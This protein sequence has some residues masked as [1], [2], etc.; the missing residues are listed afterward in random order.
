[1]DLSIIIVNYNVKHFL[2]QCLY[3]VEKAIKHLSA[4]VFVVDNNSVDG[5]V[6]MLKE[7]FLH[8]H[9]ILNNENYGF[10][11]ANNQA[12]EKATGKYILLLNP[13][14][15]VEEDTFE[16]SI[17]FM[18]ANTDAGGLG[19]KMIDGKGRF[20]PESKRSLP[21]PA[22]AF[23]KIFGF[24]KLF[25]KSKRF[26]KYHLSYLD[27][28]KTHQVE[29]LSGAFMM[30][31]KTV[32][33]KIGYLDETFFMY[34]EDIDLSYRITLAGYKNYY[35]ANTKIIHYKGESTKKG[36]INYV[37]VFYKAMIIFAKKHFKGKQVK[38]LSFLIH[39]GIFI[40]AFLSIIVR[41]AK[42]VALP[43]FDFGVIFGGLYAIKSYW[44]Y[45][46]KYIEGGHYPP[47]F[48][49]FMIPAYALVW[50]LGIYLSGGYDKPPKLLK[51]FR[52]IIYGTIFILVAYALLDEAYRYS[53]AII[54]LGAAFTFI[55][56]LLTRIV[57]HFVNTGT[58]NLE[59]ITSNRFVIIGD[60]EE[61]VRVEKLLHLTGIQTV[62]TGFVSSNDKKSCPQQIGT[63]S[64]I[65]DI[66]TIYN[67]QEIIFCAKNLNSNQIIAKMVQLKNY[68]VDFKIAP[69]QSIALIGSNSINTAGDMYVLDINT[70]IE[71][72]NKRNKRIFDVIFSVVVF[73]ASPL[74]LFIKPKQFG[75]LFYNA[76][77]VFL[78][79]KSWVGY[80]NNKNNL[81]NLPNIK[82]GVFSPVDAQ[83]IHITDISTINNLN[84]LYAKDYKV[85]KDLLI[86]IKSIKN[87][88][89]K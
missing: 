53:R 12:I 3:S 89:K 24:A 64:Q 42:Q 51:L 84:I 14:T 52:G 67:V 20:L 63:I 23:Y 1:M 40:R 68:P 8:H 36:S 85:E 5:S 69:P 34:G 54:I 58:I 70:I 82:Q 88:N 47:E 9:L 17:A 74:L 60:M 41:I 19:V 13:D 75:N 57:I 73:A 30:I 43:I 21:T 27:K 44:E 77:L 37:M 16:K 11:I 35:F 65:E 33:D 28:H 26:G 76:A 71:S 46:I 25:P 62:F 55:A 78:S 86:C 87:K 2:E 7:K 38:L 80:A 61:A 31:R 39:T 49:Y 48:T 6:E 32:L 45:N 10:S 83:K 18:N 15:L 56:L 22:V 29:V 72:S 4:E 66:I 50:L 79:R 81:D 59:K